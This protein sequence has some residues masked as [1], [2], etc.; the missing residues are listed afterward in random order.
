M[1]WFI[2]A[3]R[4]VYLQLIEQMELAIAAGEYR[5]GGKLPSVRDLAA[6]AAVNPNTMQRALQGLEARGLVN[7][8]R[9]AGR[10]ITEDEAMILALRRQKAREQIEQFWA[11]M[12]RLG[13]TREEAILLLEKEKE[14]EA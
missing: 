3:D 4:P 2:T 8:Q 6:E 13:F 14:E 1:T 11:A 5:A 12:Q 7:T 10:T 9:T